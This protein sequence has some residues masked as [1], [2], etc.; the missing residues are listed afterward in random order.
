MSDL[1]EMNFLQAQETTSNY[2]CS[3]CYGSLYCVQTGND[4]VI[5]KCHAC[6]NDTKGYIRKSY[7]KRRQQESGEE[8]MEAKYVLRQV[9]PSP[10][11]GKSE[12]QL[13][14]ELGF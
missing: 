6:G 1:T 5:V 13:L 8:L 12:E 4:R 9:I 3:N 14:K 2:V 11:Q 10:H 7:A